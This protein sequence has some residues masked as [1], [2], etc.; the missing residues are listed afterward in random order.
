MGIIPSRVSKASA[1]GSG[2]AWYVLRNQPDPAAVHHMQV[3]GCS[4]VNGDWRGGAVMMAS[5]GRLVS[6]LLL[7]QTADFALI[8]GSGTCTLMGCAFSACDKYFKE[9]GRTL[10][11]SVCL[12][13]SEPLNWS[14][15]DHI[16]KR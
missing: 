10:A 12:F 13:S 7:P 9:S 14:I 4:A 2:G 11:L 5:S 8:A 1:V 6:S 16:R 3:D 15:G